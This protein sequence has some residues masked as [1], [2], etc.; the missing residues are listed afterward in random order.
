MNITVDQDH[1]T[2]PE[3]AREELAEQGLH[4]FEMSI[5]PVDNHSHW[6]SFSTIIYVLEGELRIVDTVSDEVMLAGPGARVSVPERVL[7][8]EHSD[9]YDIVAGMSVD[10]A[11]LEG[12]VDL[13]PDLLIHE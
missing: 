11:S 5:P 13:D 1:F 7:H 3:T 10:P 9:G 12:E 2:S 8:S 4:I 6:H